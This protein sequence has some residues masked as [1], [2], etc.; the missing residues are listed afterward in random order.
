MAFECNLE[1]TPKIIFVD[2]L[3]YQVSF[4]LSYFCSVCIDF[5]FKNLPCI[6]TL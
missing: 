4:M 3:L 2:R 5:D 6:G 1:G